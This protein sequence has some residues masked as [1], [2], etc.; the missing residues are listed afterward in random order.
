M[1][2]HTPLWPLRV[3]VVIPA[4]NAARDIASALEAA[5]AFRDRIRYLMQPNRGAGAARN[6][7]IRLAADSSSRSDLIHR[8]PVEVAGQP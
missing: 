8:E 6:R 4:Y 5:L 1:R 7:G 3:T 2:A